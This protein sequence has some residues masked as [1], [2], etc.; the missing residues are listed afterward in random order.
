MATATEKIRGRAWKT[1]IMEK[2]APMK[3]DAQGLIIENRPKHLQEIRG[4]CSEELKLKYHKHI[5]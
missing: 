5:L 4:M 3:T 2:T 1:S